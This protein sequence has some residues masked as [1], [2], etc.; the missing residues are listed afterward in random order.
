MFMLSVVRDGY[1]RQSCET[2]FPTNTR[3]THLEMKGD[4]FCILI[5]VRGEKAE[6]L[7]NVNNHKM[8]PL[9]R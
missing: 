1:F 4:S 5:L 7:S 8:T 6:C 3:K 2:I 9:S